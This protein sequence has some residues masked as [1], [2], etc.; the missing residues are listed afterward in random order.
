MTSACQNKFLFAVT[1]LTLL[2]AANGVRWQGTGNMTS[3]NM[4]KIMSYIQN[5]YDGLPAKGA[6]TA[7]DPVSSV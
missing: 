1:L 3:D 5:N 6:S 2:V 4:T 7:F